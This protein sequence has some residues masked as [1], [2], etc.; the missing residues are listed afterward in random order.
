MG[1]VPAP[2]WAPERPSDGSGGALCGARMTP[3]HP[4]AVRRPVA[5]RGSRRATVGGCRKVQGHVTPCF[6]KDRSPS[7][8]ASRRVPLTSSWSP[9]GLQQTPRTV[10]RPAWWPWGPP[11]CCESIGYVPTMFP[12]SGERSQTSRSAKFATPT[13]IYT[14][15]LKKLH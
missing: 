5:T 11:R 9:H 2:P 10:P 13:K 15:C 3:V 1:V 12:G 7:H 4:A 8:R 6:T 14:I